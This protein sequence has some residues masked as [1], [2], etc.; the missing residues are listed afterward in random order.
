M[1]SL[2]TSPAY[3]VKVEP[4]L[5]TMAPNSQFLAPSL[6]QSHLQSHLRLLQR[7]SLEISHLRI[8]G[9]LASMFFLKVGSV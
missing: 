9:G 8:L 6:F 1:N 3:M 2:F 4:W 5:H 7:F